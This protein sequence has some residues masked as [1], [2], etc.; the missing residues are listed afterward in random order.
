LALKLIAALN[1]VIS[2]IIFWAIIFFVAGTTNYWQGWALLAVSIGGNIAILPV[3]FRDP[4]LLR[5][6]MNIK[7]SSAGHMLAQVVVAGAFLLVIVISPLDHRLMWSHVPL[8]LNVAGDAFVA[9]GLATLFLVL[10]VNRF[11]SATIEIA[12][13]QRVISTGIY[14]HVRH[15]CY[16][17]LMLL[18]IGIP[19]ALGSFFT[20]L[21]LVPVMA[22]LIW[23]IHDEERFLVE[24][25]P[26]YAEYLATVRWR[27]LPGVY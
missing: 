5:R 15:P 18:Y 1:A 8:W 10:R 23:R 4:E 17:G 16:V 12:E 14:A 19:L 13:D 9:A 26:G 21:V 20:L 3:V 7:E 11:A 2:M 27:L 25:L 24:K 22:M 6:R